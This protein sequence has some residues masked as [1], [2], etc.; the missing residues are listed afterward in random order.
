MSSKRKLRVAI[1]APPWIALPV[2]GY[3]G[4]ELVLEGLVSA[5]KSRNDIE[6]ELFANGERTIPGVKTHSLFK[7][8]Q[9][10]NIY[11]PFFES[12]AIV[13]AHVEFAYNTILEDGTFDI[14][15]DHNPHVGPA[16]WSMASHNKKLPPVLHTFHGPPFLAADKESS[17]SVYNTQD[18]QQIRDFGSMYASCISAA[19]AATAPENVRPRIVKPV[20]NGVDVTQF[21]FVEKKKDYFV[22]LARFAPYKGH[23]I[24]A[25]A[26][27]RLKKRLRMAGTVADIGT[28][29]KLLSEL[30]NPLSSYRSDAQFTYY[31]NEVLPYI[32]QYPRISYA[33]SLS[34]KRK[35]TFLAEAKALLFPITWEE[36]FGMSVI[37]ALACGT[38]VIAMNRG[39]MPEIIE[40]GVN[41]FL[42]NTQEEFEEYMLRIGEIDPNDCRNSVAER[43]SNEAMARGYVERY[44]EVLA[45]EQAKR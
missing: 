21:P 9:F 43:F 19:M 3:G 40:H 28:S 25:K 20:H 2:R 5:L 38:P 13:R 33:G 32:L 29:R 12:Y 36:P 23:H 22:T 1:I 44:I 8:E 6:V 11:K 10:K 34:G 45:R 4:I 27:A 16:F 26:A 35:H 15:H 42:A 37:E 41:G 7:E 30:A 14:I 39:A 31:S 18:I 17:G 24:A